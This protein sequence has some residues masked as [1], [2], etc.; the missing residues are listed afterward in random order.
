MLIRELAKLACDKGLNIGEHR[1]YRKL[2][3]W[4]MLNDNNEPYQ[5]FVNA[6]YFER[7]QTYYDTA[8]GTRLVQTTRVL[9][10]GQAYI[11]DRL[12]KEME[13]RGAL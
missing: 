12:S 6:G 5:R 8:Y 11:L 3:E 2:R 7:T 9:P 13:L 4:K 10:K 1:L